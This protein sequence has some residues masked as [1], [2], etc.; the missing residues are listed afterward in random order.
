M[1][2]YVPLIIKFTTHTQKWKYC[3]KQKIDVKEMGRA[4]MY[5]HTQTRGNTHDF[6]MNE[7]FH[8]L[9]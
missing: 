7:G 6:L 8:I 3:N 2:N 4:H 9:E 5:L 1:A